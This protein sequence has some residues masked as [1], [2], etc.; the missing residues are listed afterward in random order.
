MKDT[1]NIRFAVLGA[2]DAVGPYLADAI[3]A[4][5]G[6]EVRALVDLNADNLAKVA[7]RHPV[8]VTFG[9]Q[10]DLHNSG[11][12]IDVEVIAVPTRFHRDH[13]VAALREGHHVMGEKPLTASPEET[14]EV[15]ELARELDL[16]LFGIGQRRLMVRE[17]AQAIANGRIGKVLSAEA[18]WL[19]A[20]ATPGFAL[21]DPRGAFA[22]L[23][24]HQLK[25]LSAAL[26]GKAVDQVTGTA[27]RREGEKGEYYAH[28]TLQLGD[29]AAVIRTGWTLHPAGGTGDKAPEDEVIFQ[30]VGDR[31][32]ITTPLP[33][34]EE[35]AGELARFRPELVV[36]NGRERQVELMGEIPSVTA[37]RERE[38]REMVAL[39][40]DGIQPSLPVDEQNIAEAI[41]AFYVSER[42]GGEQIPVS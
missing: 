3:A 25:M 5:D 18:T 38:V 32:T 30:V 28:A 8:A 26:G 4:V 39:V 7:R 40:R 12:D 36:R 20:A 24:V 27:H 22:D 9:S 6:A 1:K 21:R 15:I 2:G 10:R 42:R 31:G 19:R 14:R 41:D 16:R 33:T 35:R 23:G 17:I 11:L 29:V 37:C 13:I 34:Y